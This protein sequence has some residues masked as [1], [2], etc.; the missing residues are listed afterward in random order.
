[1]IMVAVSHANSVSEKVF[2]AYETQ[3]PAFLQA[4]DP[5]NTKDMIG[6]AK[7]AVDMLIKFREAQMQAAKIANIAAKLECLNKISAS[8]G[9]AGA[10]VGF[11]FSFF[12]PG[13]GPD[14]EILKL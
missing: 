12:G 5:R 9:I 4:I 10:L 1:M 8:L 7:T 3:N 13:T 14:P 6:N 2:K 11:V